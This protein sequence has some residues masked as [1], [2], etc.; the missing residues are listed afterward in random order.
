MFSTSLWVYAFL[1]AVS[2]GLGLLLMSYSVCRSKRLE[3]RLF[4]EI[5]EVS[6][7][8][9]IHFS[10]KGKLLHFNSKAEGFFPELPDI[11]TS[12]TAL[13]D[14]WDVIYANAIDC[15][16]SI[17]AGVLKEGTFAERPPFREI[18]SFGE[19]RTGLIEVKPLRDGGSLF[20]V[21]DVSF[22]TRR[23]EEVL[24]L[25]KDNYSLQ[26]AIE[27]ARNGIVISDLK[28][29]GNPIVYA[30]RAA[31][32]FFGLSS[33]DLEDCS[34]DVFANMIQSADQRQSFLDVTRHQK[35]DGYEFAIDEDDG[36]WFSFKCSLVQDSKG[37]D[38]LMVGE[39]MDI[40]ELKQREREMFQSRKLEA[41]GEL[42]AGVSHDFNNILSIIDGFTLMAQK[43]LPEDSEA[44]EHLKRVSSASRR[45][46]ALTKK[47]ITFSRHKVRSQTVINLSDVVEEQKALLDPLMLPSVQFRLLPVDE[48]VYVR[49]S[50]D[51][52]S[53]ILMNLIINA[54]DAME[55]TGGLLTLDMRVQPYTLLPQSVRSRADEDTQYA[56]IKVEDT[57]S[58]M[59]PETLERVFDPFFSTKDQGKGTGLGMSIVY[60]LVNE[61]DGLVDIRSTPKVG[62]SISIFLPLA[63]EGEGKKVIGDA[64][65]PEQI[66]LEGYTVL[67]VEDEPDLLTVM[68]NILDDMGMT[69]LYATNGNEALMVQD[70]YEGEIDILLTDVVMPEMDGVKL[71]ELFLSLRPSTKIIFMSGYPGQG[72]SAPFELPEDVTFIPKPVDY[73]SISVTVY[74]EILTKSN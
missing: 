72:D 63:E 48:G 10:A 12:K 3:R 21:S 1:L 37:L 20:A 43:S 39:F 69:V 67:V 36:A 60:G 70:D 27:S 41:L 28:A 38:D 66:R 50:E 54:R 64:S 31:T 51:S 15:D 65:V 57:G 40:T 61:A 74:Q 73:D 68:R 4:D 42:A 6:N 56:H 14:F 44:Q 19:G 17:W 45:G 25:N 53:Q 18:L 13:S 35:A 47:M 71:R 24:H 33:Q 32:E 23:E 55:D 34:W 7:F 58:G 49:I 62:T 30:N 59:D 11:A 16:E 8:G 26:N 29:K 22:D 52:I 5:L 2:A 9:K 46:A